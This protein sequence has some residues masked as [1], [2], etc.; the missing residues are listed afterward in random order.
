MDQEQA[1]AA[2]AGIVIY[3]PEEGQLARLVAAVAPGLREVVVFANSEVSSA[4]ETQLGEAAHPVPCRILRP[5]ANVGLGA[6]Y[7]AFL[8]SA[9]AAGD[10][11]V[12]LLD[13][14]SL[15]P[16]GAVPRLAAVHARLVADGER[17]AI[18]GPQPLDP[19]GQPMKLALSG[20]PP[21]P[22]L[23]GEATRVA[24]VISSGS[25]VDVEAAATI[26]PFRADYF[27]DAI[28]LEWCFRAGARGFSI[29]VADH[30]RMDHRLGRGVIRLPVLGILLADQPPRRLYTYLRNQLAMLRL[31][32]VPAA[33]KTR[34]LLSLPLRLPVY[35]VRNGFSREARAALLNGLR[36]GIAGRLGP[37]D[38]A[39]R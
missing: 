28:D 9:R 27:I 37:P 31:P 23:A 34:M 30:V 35:L 7:D 15:P 17:P 12:L 6:A 33:H 2:S 29:W 22:V 32:H 13:Q 38:G 3:H 1:V 5:G 16:E 4:L 21:T 8:A 36:D 25:L 19:E 10:R 20:S 26:G 14:D 18:V 11:F 39:L 24:F